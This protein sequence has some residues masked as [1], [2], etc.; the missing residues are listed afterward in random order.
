MMIESRISEVVYLKVMIIAVMFAAKADNF[1]AERPGLS[2]LRLLYKS[3][4]TFIF[5]YRSAGAS[6]LPVGLFS[7]SVIF[8]QQNICDH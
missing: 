8:P 3:T 2:V 7:F 6:S 4:K 5:V 1:R